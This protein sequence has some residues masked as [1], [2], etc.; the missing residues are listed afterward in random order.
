MIKVINFKIIK[1]TLINIIFLMSFCF[2]S[3]IYATDNNDEITSYYP[4]PHTF[5]ALEYDQHLVQGD[6]YFYK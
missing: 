5:A 6:P 4:K 3:I 1:S 2:S